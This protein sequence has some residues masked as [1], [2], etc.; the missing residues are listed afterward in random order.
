MGD[1]FRNFAD[2]VKAFDNHEGRIKTL[3][4]NDERQDRELREHNRDIGVLDEIARQAAALARRVAARE[5]AARK[6]ELASKTKAA[7][8]KK[9]KP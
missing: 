2:L 3:E 4:T 8:R 1:H 7:P 5:V 6:R 9:V